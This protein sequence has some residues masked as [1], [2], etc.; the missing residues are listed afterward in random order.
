MPT[1]LAVLA[2]WA[3]VTL[4]EEAPAREAKPAPAVNVRFAEVDR[5]YERRD[6]PGELE[7]VKAG[8]AAAEKE[9]PADYELEWRL[10]RLYSWLSDDP[11]IS[12]DEKS[13]LGKIG[14][15]HA[16]RAIA[17]DPSRD[18]RHVGGPGAGAHR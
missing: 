7:K 3:T 14:W 13:K 6:E 1:P 16:E 9:G 15:E 10:A 2:L 4:A 8:L 5:A 12:D 18:R 11:A 17:L